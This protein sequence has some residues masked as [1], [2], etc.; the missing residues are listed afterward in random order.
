MYSLSQ[1]KPRNPKIPLTTHTISNFQIR[2]LNPIASYSQERIIK[3]PWHKQLWWCI[4]NQGV[5]QGNIGEI[6]TW[7]ECIDNCT[8]ILSQ[9][10]PN[11]N[12]IPHSISRTLQKLRD[13][14]IIEFLDNKGYYKVISH[15]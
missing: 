15:Y 6:F 2:C 5:I 8:D 11:N 12:T 4:I 7:R 10:R 14:R 9:F 3:E 13:K 1:I